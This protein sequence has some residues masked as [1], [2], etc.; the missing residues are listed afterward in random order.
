MAALAAAAG[1]PIG[2]AAL[3]AKPAWR[4]GLG[5]RFGDRPSATRDC[6]W[7]HGSSVGEVR[8]A[9][10]L[11]DAFAARGVPLA[12][13][14][15]TLAGRELLRRERPDVPAALAPLDHPWCVA[16]AFRRV[17]AGL[18]VLVETELWPCWIHGA[19]DRGAAVAIVSGR[20]SDRSFPR[21]RRVR[22]ALRPVLGALVAIGAR[23]ERDAERFVALGAPPARVSVT[24]DLKLDPPARTAPPAAELA[25]FVGETPLFVAAS[26]HAGEDEAA[27]G[28]LASARE[29]GLAAALVLAPRHADRFDAVAALVQARG[30]PLLRRSRAPAR[31]LAA[32]EVLL[33]DSLG[34]LLGLYAAAR[35]VFVGGTLAPRG[36]HSVVE[37]AL[38]GRAPLFGPHTENTRDAADLLLAAGGARRVADARGL[39]AAL[40]DA[41]RDPAGEAARGARAREALAPHRGATDRSLAL[42]ERLRAARTGKRT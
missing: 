23:S 41:L 26:T 38:A 17:P 40:V 15:S 22:A 13:S 28:A 8:A 20:I 29:A 24:G 39:A 14:A 42:L 10:R 35:V 33:L 4:H 32:G 34:E 18:L 12:A 7:V 19:R 21:Y 3:A 30:V 5:E 1:L 27:L 16:R 25:A 9:F 2:L 6:V 11:L 31:P 36:G 37:P